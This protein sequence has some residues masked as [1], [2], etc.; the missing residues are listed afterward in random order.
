[1]KLFKNISGL[2][3][4][5]CLTLLTT[6]P[7]MA[8]TSGHDEHQHNDHG[9]TGLSLNQGEKWHSDVPLRQGMQSINHA[10]I[11]AVPA[12]HRG[13]LTQ[14]NAMQLAKH[15]NEQIEFL[16]QNCKLT[17]Q[18]DAVL[19]IVIA[20][21]LAGAAELAKQPSSMQG[22]PRIVGALQQYPIYFD[23]PGWT[24]ISH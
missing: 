9:A 17:P 1:M 8:Q 3:A 13:A 24:E 10:V 15:I 20:D 21:L 11:D 14:P 5:I 7:V 18:A 6:M 4:A 16:V 23:Q 12:F 19:H 2:A 22:L